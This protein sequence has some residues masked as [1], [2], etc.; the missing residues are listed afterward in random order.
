MMNVM[1]SSLHCRLFTVSNKCSVMVTCKKGNTLVKSGRDLI[2]GVRT[3]ASLADVQHTTRHN[4][5]IFVHQY[6]VCFIVSLKM[7]VG[8]K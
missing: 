1:S 4:A 7:F 3:K 2:G 6:S 8:P 5:N